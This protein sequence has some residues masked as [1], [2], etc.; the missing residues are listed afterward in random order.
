MDRKAKKKIHKSTKFEAYLA[1]VSEALNMADYIR[2]LFF[3]RFIY[4]FKKN[5]QHKQLYSKLLLKCKLHLSNDNQSN[6]RRKTEE[7]KN[8]ERTTFLIL[9]II[10]SYT[11]ACYRISESFVY[12]FK[13]KSC[14]PDFI[15]E[16]S[17]L[18]IF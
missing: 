17:S 4:F 9:K 13:K 10:S 18:I 6:I 5:N 2:F 12:A 7:Q 11:P 1:A 15:P 14:S 16:N 3:R 8:K